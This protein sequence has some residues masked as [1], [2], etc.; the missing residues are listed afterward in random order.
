MA[1]PAKSLVKY[2]QRQLN[3]S[4]FRSGRVD[5]ICGWRTRGAL[6]KAL[7]DVSN[8]DPK[9]PQERLLSAYIQYLATHRGIDAGPIDGWW[10]P[11]TEFGYEN[12]LHL[13]EHGIPVPNWRDQEDDYVPAQNHWPEERPESEL[14]KYYGEPGSNLATIELPYVHRI[15]WSSSQT[16]SKFSCHEK[17][18]ESMKRVLTRVLDYYGAQQIRDLRL[19]YWG[20]CFNKRTIRGGSRWSTHAW[21]IAVDYDPDRNRLRWGRDRAHFAKPAYEKWWQLWEEEGWV[22]LG[23]IKNY[24]W[25]H[26]QAAKR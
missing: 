14:R 3:A 13:E 4:G 6:R 7:A 15:A 20:G 1:Q 16:L 8:V 5:G 2:V 18:A 23:R 19:D 10:G 11:Q 21:G 24:D 12:L 17:V 22:S 26:V 9:W 25:M